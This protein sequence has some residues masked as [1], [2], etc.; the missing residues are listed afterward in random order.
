MS[1]NAVICSYL[2]LGKVL[3][4]QIVDSCWNTCV[5]HLQLFR[6]ELAPISIRDGVVELH[7]LEGRQC[8]L[9]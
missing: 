9:I 2:D 8:L 6:R 7:C 1:F 4:V 3:K 5:A